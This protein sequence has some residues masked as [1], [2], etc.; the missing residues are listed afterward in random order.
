MKKEF[1][2]LIVSLII[3]AP[4]SNAQILKGST[5]LGG[6]LGFNTSKTKN[7]SD[8]QTNFSFSPVLGIAISDNTILGGSL[9]YAIHK[10]NGSK[11]SSNYG[12]G[13]FV[14]KY[15]PLGHGFYLFG[16]SNLRFDYGTNKEYY[17]INQNM[18]EYKNR[19]YMVGIG[20]NP[21]LSYA[22]SK[23]LHLE[24]VFTDI[25]SVNYYWGKREGLGNATF[26]NRKSNGFSLNSN[27]SLNG[28]NSLGIGIRFLLNKST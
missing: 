22:L 1:F 4:F 28:I 18:E 9:R 13:I 5:L 2:T 17:S 19:N 7:I 8:K 20:L 26:Y 11:L 10:I 16:E 25:V 27:I 14:R 12:A 21:G 6:S 24:L 15:K 23:R 3:L